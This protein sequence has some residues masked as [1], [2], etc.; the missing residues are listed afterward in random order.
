M[1]KW[2]QSDYCSSRK[3]CSS[4]RLSDK[5]REWVLKTYEVVD[6]N[7]NYECPFGITA[8][9]VQGKFPPIQVEAANAAKAL[10]RVAGS[11]LAGN[12]I[13]V[14]NT[15]R[16]RR[17]TIC[18]S[19]K[20]QMYHK[21]RCKKC[22]CITRY[23]VVLST[24]N[25]PL[26]YWDESKVT[27]NPSNSPSRKAR[28]I[29]ITTVKAALE[30]ALIEAC[31]QSNL[32][33]S[34]SSNF[35]DYKSAFRQTINIMTWGVKIPTWWYHKH[36]AN[37]LFFEN[38]LLCQSAG[39]WIDSRGWFS[40]SNLCTQKHYDEPYTVTD[41]DTVKAIVKRHFDWELF[42]GGNPNGPIMYAVQSINDASCKYHF[43]ARAQR[44]E[45]TILATLRLLNKHLPDRPLIIRPHPRFRDQWQRS[46]AKYTTL[47]R[48]GWKMDDSKNV[49]DTLKDC[50]AVVGVNS[51]VLTEAL[52]LGIPVGTLGESAYTGSNAT[53]ECARDPSK[54]GHLMDWVP[55]KEVI[56]RYL[57]SLVHGHQLPFNCNADFIASNREFQAW[58]G[59]LTN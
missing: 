5:F 13:K 43:P 33:L 22:G 44:T 16:D 41:Y 50:S 31:R 34:F 7:P 23:K 35:D 17:L 38:G 42:Q 55:N 54:L 12:R 20:C 39:V 25:C 4:C 21:D 18:K 51:T 32:E 14:S 58:L 27:P 28:A 30:K 53:L 47:F 8:D 15:E 48:S 19:N 3:H 6:G 45:D 37:V 49:Y 36:Q 2:F 26:G 56:L 11:V 24:E 52:A 40:E 57:C 9:S 59:R 10:A 1:D 46:K 29:L